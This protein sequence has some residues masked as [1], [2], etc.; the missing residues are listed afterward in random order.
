MVDF[1]VTPP[2]C[3]EGHTFARLGED[4]FRL[5]ETG[6]RVLKLSYFLTSQSDSGLNPTLLTE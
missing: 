1:F 3:A 5:I 4:E 2:H 6:R